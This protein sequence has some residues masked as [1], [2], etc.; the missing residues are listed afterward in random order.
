MAGLERNLENR[1]WLVER[2]KAEIIGPDPSGEFAATNE[3]GSQI[4]TWEEFRKPKR[5]INGE[6]ILW[7]DAPIKRYGSGILFPQGLTEQV[8]LAEEARS[9]PEATE[10]TDPGPDIRADEILEKKIQDDVSKIKVL[11]D[12]TEN[13]DVMLANAYRPSA[14][15]ISFLADFSLEN[16][17]F[18]IEVDCATYRKVKVRVGYSKETEK[19]TDR[20]VWFRAPGQTPDGGKPFIKVEKSKILK[21]I[22]PLKKW[23]P[24]FEGRLELVIVPRIYGRKPDSLERLVTVCLINRQRKDA[25]RVDEQCFFQCGFRIQ[26]CSQ[27]SWILPYPEVSREKRDDA[28]EAEIIRLIYRDRQTFAIGHGCAANWPE[29]RPERV[30]KLWTECMPVFETPAISA[31]IADKNGDPLRVSMRKL[32]G[33]DPEENGREEM[34]GLLDAYRKWIKALKDLD[35]QNPPIT[36]DLRGTAGILIQRCEE[37]LKRMEDGLAFLNENTKTAEYA[38]E[39]FRLANHAMLLAQLRSSREVRIPR[40]EDGRILWDKSINNPDPAQP[41]PNKGY[42]RAFQIAFLLMSLRGICNQSHEDR[43]MVDLIWFPTGGGKTEAYLGLAAFTIFFNRLAG[44]EPGGV[45]VIMRYTLR[46]LTAQQF[47]RAG[48]L[49]CAMEFIRNLPS[50]IPRLNGKQFRLGIWVGGD[51]TPNTR[52]N[53]KAALRALQKDSNS[54]NPFVLLKC[55]WCNA[56]FGPA[57]DSSPSKKDGLK[58]KGKKKKGS[59]PKSVYGYTTSI[60]GGKETVVFRCD[61]PVCDFGL[62]PRKPGSPPLPIVVIDEDIYENPPNMLIGTVDKFALLPW[63]PEIRSIFGITK[64]GTH[65]GVPPTLIIQDELHLISGPLGSMVGAY[66]TIVE[67]LCTKR[68]GDMVISPKIVA[69]TATISRADDQVKALYA[70]DQ[71][72]LFPPSGLDAGDSFFAREDRYDDGTLKPGRLYVGI[73]APGHGSLQTTEARVFATLLQYPVIMDILNGDESERDPWW[74]LLSFFNSLRELGGAATLLV[75][76][77]RDYLRVILNRHGYPYTQIRQLLNWEELTSRVR[78]DRIPLIIQK[79]EIPFSR[80]EKGYVKDTVEVCLASNIIEVGVDIDRLSLMTIVGQPKTTSQYIQVSG[81]IGRSQEAPGLVAVMYSQSKPRDRSHFE[82]FRSYHQRLFAQ[83]EPTSV[84]PFSPPAIDRA[85]HAIIVGIERQL[86]SMKNA[87]N[88]RPFPLTKGTGLRER[89]ENKIKQRAITVDPDEQQAVYKKFLQRLNE[90][91]AWNPSE[92]G[93]FGSVPENPPLMFPAGSLE[94]DE[95]NGHSW[96]TLSSLRDVD[97]TCEAEITTYYNEPQEDID[98]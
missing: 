30:G 9:T 26:G 91:R 41:T 12:D 37:S 68:I 94:P 40:L 49:F 59:S 81:R 31:D 61:D 45:D 20:V 27:F 86:S 28:D 88:P 60:I 4:L 17:G 78:S 74:T 10:E 35:R 38:R 84:T 39:A 63:K 65:S 53:A 46:L 51:A 42:W 44:L 80:D 29:G 56:K 97:A 95:W 70:R 2:L 48:L 7:Q 54:E 85:L 11:A 1:R 76:D 69:S 34:A 23:V 50:N 32:A 24:G 79:L 14:M 16:E 90:W 43:M 71:V 36:S 93:G 83:V 96:P 89:V 67:E 72:M 57:D 22:S 3:D 25:G 21:N 92:Y 15:G 62:D 19:L 18:N 87:T 47:Q 82:R 33:L 58:G 98:V 6:E 55:P 75:A 64:D 13:Y 8:T 73:M 5:Q 66:E 52:A 77:A